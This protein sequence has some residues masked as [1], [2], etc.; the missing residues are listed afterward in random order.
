MKKLSLKLRD[1]IYIETEEIVK[2][3]TFSRNSYINQA[4][5]YYNKVH[6]RSLLKARPHKESKLVAGESMKILKEFEYSEGTIIKTNKK[7]LKKILK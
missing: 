2:K 7:N 1:D 6:K 4:L 3:L 5:D